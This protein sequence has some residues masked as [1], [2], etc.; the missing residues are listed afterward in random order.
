MQ[1]Q[2][3][4]LADIDFVHSHLGE[5]LDELL[6]KQQI[7]RFHAA[8]TE[9]GLDDLP[10]RFKLAR[11]RFQLHFQTLSPSDS[12][13]HRLYELVEDDA[14]RANN[15]SIE[16]EDLSRTQWLSYAGR[17]FVFIVVM[18][19]LG[20]GAYRYLWPH[21]STPFDALQALTYESDLIIENPG[22]RL[23]FLTQDTVEMNHYFTQVPELGFPTPQ[24]ADTS[25]D[26]SLELV[27]ASS[28]NYEVA[29]VLV[30]AFRYKETGEDLLVYTFAGR[31]KDFPP[32]DLGTLGDFS[33]Q[34]YA[35]DSLNIIA[36][37]ANEKTVGMAVGR[38]GPDSMAD[39]AAKL[40]TR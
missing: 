14:T 3:S 10:D 25:A 18:G 17:L 35:T 9:H 20:F 33:Y 34:A 31:L 4:A 12:L 27:G 26:G 36:W 39:L 13:R 15:E 24:F 11:G 32:S 21:Q 7:E 23:D 30:A 5:Y 1:D 19:V 29:K 38:R 8:L 2:T 28:I 40:L 6:E 37:Q 16:I 22:D